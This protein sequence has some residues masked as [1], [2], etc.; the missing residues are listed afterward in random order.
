MEDAILGNEYMKDPTNPKFLGVDPARFGFPAD[1]AVETTPTR[2]KYPRANPETGY[3]KAGPTTPP[4][5]QDPIA[6]LRQLLGF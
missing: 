6:D 1:E 2:V 3:Y 5:R 4:Q